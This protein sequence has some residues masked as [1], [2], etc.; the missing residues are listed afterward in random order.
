MKVL[1]FPGSSRA[2][3]ARF[4]IWQ[5]VSPLKELGHEVKVRV[6]KPERYWVPQVRAGILNRVC[7]YGAGILR[8]ISALWI[9]R[10]V[11]GFDVIMMNRDLVPEPK[12]SFLEICLSKRNPRLI[13]DFD[14]AIFL[15][16]REHK[17][18]K[19]LPVFAAVTA[20]NEYLATFARQANPRVEIWPTVVDT[21]RFTPIKQ[22]HPGPLRIGWS[23]SHSTLKSCLPLLE[24]VI[25]EFARTTLFELLIIADKAPSFTWP[26]VKIKYIPWSPEKEV[27]TLQLFDF[28]L[29]P[30][31]D[32]PFERGKCGAKALTYMAIGIPAVVS[33]VGV[34]AEIVIPGEHGFHCRT[35]TEWLQAFRVLADDPDLR[36]EMGRKAVE[37]VKA[38]YSVRSLV[39]KMVSTFEALSRLGK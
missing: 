5:F 36:S 11:K 24:K 30:L 35:D 12:I 21:D 34:N 28:G 26:G 25:T 29:M 38:Y 17:L 14:D 20:G 2:P 16:P 15:G 7:G 27:E 19:I 9:T 18:R 6:L 32:S 3:A 23:G 33:P 31:K 4:R 13:F 22:R 10:G 8:L 37:R 1:L 39:P